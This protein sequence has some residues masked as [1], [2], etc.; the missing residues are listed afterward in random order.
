MRVVAKNNIPIGKRM[1][2][3]D[4]ALKT[5]GN[6]DVFITMNSLI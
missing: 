4:I 6:N 1:N 5:T 3:N 2:N